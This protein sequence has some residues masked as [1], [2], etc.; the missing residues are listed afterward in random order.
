MGVNS[1]VGVSV[2]VGVE[3]TSGVGVGSGSPQRPTWIL[4]PSTDS[5]SEKLERVNLKATRVLTTKVSTINNILVMGK[6][7]KLFFSAWTKRWFALSFFFPKQDFFLYIQNFTENNN[8][9]RNNNQKNISLL[10]FAK[11]HHIA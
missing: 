10:S 1:G 2:G 8:C 4:L 11:S 6:I 5:V 7:T 9:C 3:I